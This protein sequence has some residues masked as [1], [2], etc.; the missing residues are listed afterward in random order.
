MTLKKLVS[1]EVEYAP[2]FRLSKYVST[3]SGLQL[4]HLNNKSTPLVQGY[5]AVATE[6]PTDSGVPHTLEHLIFMGSKKY[7]FKGLLDTAGNLCMSNTNAWTAT[8][9]TVYT[10]TTAGWKGFKKLLP[11][12]LDHLFHPTITDEACTTEVYHIDP[13]DLTDKGVVFSE[14]EGIESQSWFITMLEKQR[15]LFPNGSGYRSETG[16]LTPNLRVLTN[17][18]IRNFHK[19]MYAPDN[20]CLIITGNIPEDE[21]LKIVTEF[22][23]TLS[24]SNGERKR[25]FVDTPESQIPDSLATLKETTVAFPEADE[26]Q[27]EL[28]FAW[29]TKPY[30]NHLEDLAVN[31]LLEYL[32]ESPLALFNKEL[33]EIEDPYATEADYWTDDFVKTIANLTLKGV[34]TEKLEEAKQKTLEILAK[35]SVSLE[36]VR[37]VVDN[38]KWDYVLKCEKNGDNIISQTCITDF[39]YGDPE[40]KVLEAT[41]KSLADFETLL[42]WEKEEWQSLFEK[43][44]VTNKPV[45]VVGVPSSSLNGNIE[46]DTE[47]RLQERRKAFDEAKIKELARVLAH[48]QEKNNTPIPEETLVDFEI[49]DPENAVK[50]IDTKSITTIE[51]K[52]ND[53]EDPL[54]RKILGSRPENF[55]LYI[56]LEHFH[57]QFI[58]LHVLLNSDF[59]KD[60]KILPYYHVISELFSMPMYDDLNNIVPYEDV[61]AQLKRETVDINIGL[62]LAGD[63]P[64]L[65]D[66]KIECKSTDYNKAVEWIRNVLFRSIFDESRVSIL[67]DKF[68]NSIVETKREGD[69]MMS[70]LMNRRL[71]TENSLKKATDEIFVEEI[72]E[73]ILNE[74]QDGN[75]E[76]KVLPRIESLRTQL[77]AHLSKSHILI[78]GNIELLDDVYKPWEE[79]IVPNMRHDENLDVKIPPTPRSMNHLSK[80]GKDPR[81]MAYLV[82]TPASESTYMTV[83]TSL[84]LKLNYLHPDFPAI[85]LAAE[86]LQCVEGP[87]WK[88]IRGSG[89]AYGAYVSKMFESNGIGFFVYRAADALKC[90]E[91]GKK[92]VENFASGNLAFDPI[93]VKGAISSIINGIASS[94]SGYLS[95]GISKYI[96]NFCK[97]RGPNFN[98]NFLRRLK[99]TTVDDLQR[100]M[101]QWFGNIFDVNKGSVFVACHPSKAE[102]IQ[103]FLEAEGYT[104]EVEELFDDEQSE[105]EGEEDATDSSSDDE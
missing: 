81:R 67:L 8:D 100:V 69:Q 72:V 57:S 93:L 92:I 49:H 104:I 73:N 36:R 42:K 15:L 76:T 91:V 22:D 85:A 99:E 86:Y 45:I 33:V 47:R 46:K 38:M 70:S 13:N 103:E 43:T 6:C 28:V 53:L 10:L 65:I 16:G 64:D 4:I 54:T 29:I 58:E 102:N 52:L 40:G 77:L 78:L 63:F 84:P 105:E 11:V 89:L 14:M 98:E 31:M 68:Y 101:K 26:S 9:Q 95:A 2:Q 80:L 35:H 96:D 34:P 12:Y 82:I 41:I 1:F 44:F 56:H 61:V 74:I 66:I 90:Y 19:S 75:Y 55:P 51:D 21:L 27:G 7:P 60:P 62:G 97:E 79:F 59:I 87:F 39:L 5:F 30:L 32:T 48:A 37:L 25:P 88:G 24:E 3:H 17:D 18:E 23:S 20:C 94:E 71:Y 50:L 83:M